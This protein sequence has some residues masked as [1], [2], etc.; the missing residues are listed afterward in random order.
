MGTPSDRA[1]YGFCSGTRLLATPGGVASRVQGSG[2][3]AGHRDLR[4]CQQGTELAEAIY[5]MTSPLPKEE[6]YGLVSQMNRA[7][8]SVPSSIGEGYGRGGQDS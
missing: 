7:A 5:K 2:V 4:V 8:V 3:M 1:R 6:T